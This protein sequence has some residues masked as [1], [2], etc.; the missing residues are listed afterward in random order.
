MAVVDFLRFPP[1]PPLL[2][3]GCGRY[4]ALRKWITRRR[5]APPL[6]CCPLACLQT[7]SRYAEV[8]NCCI[9]FS[10]ALRGRGVSKLWQAGEVL[11]LSPAFPHLL[12]IT[13]GASWV[14]PAASGWG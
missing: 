4:V 11:R 13:E 5:S 12:P 14:L 8:F 6:L 10:N 7:R 3:Y 1:F 9:C 2:L